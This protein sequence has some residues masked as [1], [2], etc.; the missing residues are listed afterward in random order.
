ML[1]EDSEFIDKMR[2][3][4]RDAGVMHAPCFDVENCQLVERDLRIDLINVWH[5]TNQLRNSATSEIVENWARPKHLGHA[6]YFG[7]LDIVERAIA[8][9]LVLDGSDY[10]GD[11][12][13]AAIE[14]WVVTPLHVRCVELLYNAGAPATLGQ[15]QSFA[16]ESVGN[17]PCEQ[18][19]LELLLRQAHRS[20]DPAVRQEAVEWSS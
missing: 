11:P 6:C 15:F 5:T 17:D 14:A 20:T 19:L 18:V 1:Y 3:V 9:G 7:R 10:G 13:A 4:L 16:A 8:L 2:A 12:V